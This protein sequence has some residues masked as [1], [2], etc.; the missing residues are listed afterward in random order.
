MV[1]AATHKNNSVVH[2]DRLLA[3]CGRVDGAVVE[4][5]SGENRPNTI[6]LSA[7]ERKLTIDHAYPVLAGIVMPCATKLAVAEER[8]MVYLTVVIVLTSTVFPM[9]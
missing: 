4:S 7:G 8:V 3:L 2:G 5:N 1:T 9:L 6:S